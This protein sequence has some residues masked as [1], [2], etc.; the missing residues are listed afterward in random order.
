MEVKNLMLTLSLYLPV[1]QSL[2]QSIKSLAV[3]D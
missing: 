1:R 2:Y 3:R